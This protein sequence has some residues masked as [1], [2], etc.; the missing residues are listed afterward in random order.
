MP[1]TMNK[2]K[3]IVRIYFFL[4]ANNSFL[5][6]FSN[7]KLS[8]RSILIIFVVEQVSCWVYCMFIFW[9]MQLLQANL[10][11][12][13]CIF[14]FHMHGQCLGAHISHHRHTPWKARVQ[15]DTSNICNIINNI[16]SLT[17]I[18]Y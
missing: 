4:L 14:R 8:N 6:K 18:L 10:S 17:F 2:C 1:S 9:S 13:H 3:I 12:S 16:F 15:E 5:T 7:K 11:L